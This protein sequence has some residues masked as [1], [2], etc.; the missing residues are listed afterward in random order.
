MKLDEVPQDSSTVYGGHSKLL[1]AVDDSGHYQGAQSAG[2]EPETYSTQLAVAE[3]QEQETEAHAA[4]QRGELSPLKFLMYR[5]RLDEPA[6][7]MVTGLWQWRI[8]RHFRPA[9]YRKLSPALL[10]RYAEAFG[11]PVEQ[12]ISYQKGQA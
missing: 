3:L 2:W 5:Y 12:L 9:I 8:R 6:L 1:Y 11:L 4:W 7:A 10:A